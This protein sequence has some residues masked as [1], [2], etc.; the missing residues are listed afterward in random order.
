MSGSMGATMEVFVAVIAFAGAL[1]AAIAVG[2]L[3]GRLRDEPS[4]WLTAWTIA[5]VALC[6]SLGVAATGHLIG[7]GSTTFRSFQ[8]TGSLLAPLWLAVGVLQLLAEK[9]AARFAGWLLGI[10]LT[11]VG[12]VILLFDPLSGAFAKELPYGATHWDIW[13][14]WLLRGVHG[15]VVAMLVISLAIA[16]L[17]WRDGDDYDAD[18]MNA[19]VALA[20]AGI[21]LAVSLEFTLPGVVVIVLMMAAVGA[22]WYAVARPLAPYEDEDEEVDA[23]AD[24][25]QGR[26]HRAAEDRVEP[27]AQAPARRSGLG[28]LVAEYR[29]G[30]QGEVDYAARMQP[31]DGFGGPATGQIMSSDPYGA[32]GKPEYGMPAAQS[33]QEYGMPAT[34]AMFPGA[35]MGPGAGGGLGPAA[36]PGP[37]PAPPGPMPPGS[38]PPGSMPP[39]SVPPGPMGPVPPGPMGPMPPGPAG[40]MQSGPMGPMPPGPPSPGPLQSGPMQSSPMQG[41]TVKPSP[42]IY[43]LLTVFTLMDGSGDAFDRLAEETVEAVQRSEPDTLIFVCHGVKSAPLQRIVYELYRDEVGFT[44]HQRQPHME[45]FATERQA[46][47]LATNVIEL[48]VNAAKVVPL[49]T[50]FR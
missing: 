44:E 26:D 35:E 13:P 7:F 22:I 15:L 9:A 25:W 19:S 8:I 17:S 33:K 1:L 36:R 42:S 24:E 47:V 3:I 20:P 50:T 29:A 2:V 46:L 5:T 16:L 12:T 27:P 40:P 11:V 31:A 37:A 4:G 32:P 39:G 45:R 48:T 14:E 41:G 43:G 34:G 28:D 21:A 18:N 10:A 38:M 30:E 23:R 49:P 6:L